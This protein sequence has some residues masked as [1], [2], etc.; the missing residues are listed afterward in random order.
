MQLKC[1]HASL[2][3]LATSKRRDTHVLVVTFGL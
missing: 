3:L 2:V 1:E